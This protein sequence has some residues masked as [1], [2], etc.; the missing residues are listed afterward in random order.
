MLAALWDAIERY[1]YS[2]TWEDEIPSK[3]KTISYY[4]DEISI[5]NLQIVLND[6]T[7]I[8]KCIKVTEDHCSDCGGRINTVLEV[9]YKLEDNEK[10]TELEHCLDYRS[11]AKRFIIKCLERNPDQVDSFNKVTANMKNFENFT[12]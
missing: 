1:D 11:S 7:V 9:V 3:T 2:F 10:L 6:D 12:K 8:S 5:E 4:F